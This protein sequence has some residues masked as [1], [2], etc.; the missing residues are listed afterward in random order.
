ML[1]S[2]RLMRSLLCLAVI[3]LKSFIYASSTDESHKTGVT[4]STES[5]PYFYASGNRS[6]LHLKEHNSSFPA[7]TKCI[8]SVR[9]ILRAAGLHLGQRYEA[10]AECPLGTHD[11]L[12]NKCRTDQ[13]E[14]APNEEKETKLIELESDLLQQLQTSGKPRFV[15]YHK[16][17][18]QKVSPVVYNPTGMVFANIFCAQC[19]LPYI[20]GN[21]RLN[22][23]F[24]AITKQLL[25]DREIDKIQCFVY[26]ELGEKV[27]RCE[28]DTPGPR[29]MFSW[30]SILQL[31]DDIFGGDEE[32]AEEQ[33]TLSDKLFDILQWICCVFSLTALSLAIAVFSC[34]SR[35]RRPLPGKMLV[36]LCCT[37]LGAI[38]A[39]LLA[40][41]LMELVPQ[42]GQTARPLCVLFAVLLQTFLLA[43]FA[44]MALFAVELLR[45]F[46]LARACRN[47]CRNLFACCD[48]NGPGKSGRGRGANCNA[49]VSVF[50]AVFVMIVLKA[51]LL[52]FKHKRLL[53]LI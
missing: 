20:R 49:A 39:F 16:L 19:H 52:Y 28:K 15:R 11:E 27:P 30:D 25:C 4:T 18:I 41:G 42:I 8:G 12:A 40:S 53:V 23:N 1:Y 36:A 37:L 9:G 7:Y 3:S 34:S 17:A 29:M 50:P 51:R 44:W 26:A 38:I 24:S 48:R 31:P 35:L 46:G 6:S 21:Q 2:D 22:A 45:T 47:A 5:L 43:S 14:F 32:E 33:K 13:I 10:I